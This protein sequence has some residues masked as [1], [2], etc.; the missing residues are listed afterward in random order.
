MTHLQQ[1][2]VSFVRKNAPGYI[3][4]EKVVKA[5]TDEELLEMISLQEQYTAS[6]NQA[7]DWKRLFYN[8]Y[9]AVQGRTL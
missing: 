8:I 6:F 2:Q 1:K 7:Q 4:D 9:E 5:A 3:G